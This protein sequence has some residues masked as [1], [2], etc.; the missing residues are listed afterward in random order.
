LPRTTTPFR[1]SKTS[2]TSG[3]L[4]TGAP[5]QSLA[6]PDSTARRPVGNMLL[7]RCIHVI[8]RQKQRLVAFYQSTFLHCHCYRCGRDVI[9]VV[10]DWSPTVK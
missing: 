2:A 5:S 10:G 6:A 8:G 1:F 9:R 3:L 7:K 4:A